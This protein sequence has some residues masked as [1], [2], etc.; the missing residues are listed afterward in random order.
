MV[1]EIYAGFFGLLFL[2]LAWPIAVQRKQKKAGLAATLLW[3]GLLPSPTR[4]TDAM[5][6]GPAT[7]NLSSP[8]SPV[9]Y[10]LCK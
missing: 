10:P 6:P 9:Y 5:A 1:T 4:N 8:S 2:V 7:V 3:R